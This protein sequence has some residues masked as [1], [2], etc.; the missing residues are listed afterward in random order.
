MD[1]TGLRTLLKDRRFAQTLAERR[2][3]SCE[4]TARLIR[5]TDR[6]RVIMVYAA[7]DPEVETLV[8]INNML[9]AGKTIVVPIIEKE[10]HTLR[11]SRLRSVSALRPSTFNVPEPIGSEIPIDA[12]A[13]ECVILPMVGFDRTGN[14]LGYGAGYYDRFLAANPSLYKIGIAYSCQEVALVPTDAYDIRM[15]EIIT[16][17]DILKF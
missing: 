14:R 6:Y 11:L 4:I 17:T 5:E 13:V 7:K 1:K 8:Y 2:R 10:T 9:A 3:N 15:D 12:S 16:E